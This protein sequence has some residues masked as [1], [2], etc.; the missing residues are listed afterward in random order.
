MPKLSRR[1]CRMREVRLSRISSW[2]RQVHGKR[3]AVVAIPDAG[4]RD[5]DFA[6][7]RATQLAA[8]QHCLWP[9]QGM[10]VRPSCSNLKWRL[11]RRGGSRKDTHERGQSIAAAQTERE[12]HGSV[13]AMPW[14]ARIEDLRFEAVLAAELASQHIPRFPDSG[15]VVLRTWC[16]TQLRDAVDLPLIVDAERVR[17]RLNVRHAVRARARRRPRIQLR[18][19]M[20]K[21]CATRRQGHIYNRRIAGKIK[22]AWTHAT[23]RFISCSYRRARHHWDGALGEHAFAAAGAT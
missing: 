2:E 18:T 17:Q 4:L 3:Y 12:W 16:T 23:A 21:R 11:P 22:A 6:S 9:H 13:A 14:P 1:P 7:A 8:S 5:G 15:C 19:I 10:L 20:P